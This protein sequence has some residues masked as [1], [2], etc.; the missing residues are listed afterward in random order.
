[1]RKLIIAI[2]LLIG[3]QSIS[4]EYSAKEIDAKTFEY[5][6]AENWKELIAF[7]K[8]N[9]QDYYYFNVRMGVA[10]FNK[11]EYYSA[12]K[13]FKKAIAQ[14]PTEYAKEFLFWTYFNMGESVLAE[15]V[16]DQLSNKSKMNIDY[17][18]T[19]IEYVYLEGGIKRPNTDEVEN[20]YYGN[21]VLKHRL[22]KNIKILHSINFFSQDPSTQNFNSYQYHLS[23]T[24][25]NKTSA[26]S[27][28]GIYN[29]NEFSYFSSTEFT[30]NFG[31]QIIEDIEGTSN[32]N[33]YSVY[34]N[35]NKRLNR[36][37]I[38]ANFNFA[39]QNAS[40]KILTKLYLS[41]DGSLISEDLIK[42]NVTENVFIPSVGFLYTPKFTKDRVSVGADFF[43]AFTQTKNNFI[44]K[45][46]LNI[47]ASKN[48]WFN[49]S[50][51]QVKNHL[52]ADY[53]SEIIYNTPDL[54]V[55]RFVATLN[56]AFTPKIITKLTY[57]FENY[58]FDTANLTYD[59]NSIFLGLQYK[60]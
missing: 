40:Q 42:S 2:V 45:P 53:S 9:P 41:E 26:F 5:F 48:M 10:F 11:Q 1:M 13:Y 38:N 52:F 51:L 36:L 32:G 19:A 15:Q 34:A 57:T 28:G 29:R 59:I 23:G 27:L 12:E 14:N 47:Y 50:Y 56:Y 35:Y 43:F 25:F 6:S 24:Y 49:T 37:R 20:T 21:L 18:K 8:E 4:Q 44:F 54:S 46:Y 39:T 30:G 17:K 31:N 22:G 58:D 33:T 55:N 60:F 16:Y 7:G 3:F